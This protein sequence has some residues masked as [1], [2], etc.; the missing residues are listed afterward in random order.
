MTPGIGTRRLHHLLDTFGDAASVW[1]ASGAE[2]ANAGLD[3]KVIANVLRLR[4]ELDLADYA[5][6]VERADARLIIQPDADYPASLRLLSDAP[7]VIF[8]RGA[9]LPSDELAVA[10]VGT[11][12]ATAYGRE[13]ARKLAGELAAAGVT[14]ISGLAHGIDAAAHKAALEAGGRTFA[15]LGCGIDR[16]YPRDHAGL[17]AQIVKNGSILTEFPLGSQPEARHFPRRNRIIS[18]LSLGVIV[19]EAPERSGAL[20]TAEFALE[21]G[22][23]VYAVPGSIFSP[24]SLGAHRLIQDGAKIVTTVEEILEDLKITNEQLMT[25]A[26]VVETIPLTATQVQLLRSF[27]EES[28]HI[29]E[30]IRLSG[31]TTE[32]AISTLTSL[33]LQGYI[34]QDRGGLYCLNY[35]AQHLLR[36]LQ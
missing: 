15:V 26:A 28:I 25:R 23:D 34:E 32:A 29:D 10:I 16:I 1:S 8:A 4:Q 24:A 21:Q 12:S 35:S 31:L 5:S 13:V 30:I 3:A 33:E 6:K 14:I 20:I 11:R 2:L 22:R 7:P 9:L 19:V 18:G 36:D 27:G 17:A